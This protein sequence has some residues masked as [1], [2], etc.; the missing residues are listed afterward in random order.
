MAACEISQDTRKLQVEITE[1][2]CH[3]LIP[4]HPWT[5][6][7]AP[8]APVTVPCGLL[9]HYH[10]FGPPQGAQWM[11]LFPTAEQIK[12]DMKLMSLNC[13]RNKQPHAKEDPAA[14]ECEGY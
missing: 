8:R 14:E 5:S 1:H 6:T 11:G 12:A 13:Q 2:A 4:N 10:L 9:T 7:P 3:R